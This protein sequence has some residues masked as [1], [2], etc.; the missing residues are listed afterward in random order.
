M[1]YC[2]DN[3]INQDEPATGDQASQ[4]SR[5]A[6]SSISERVWLAIGILLFLFFLTTTVAHLLT[7]QIDSE[8][9]Q[10][11][12]AFELVLEGKSESEPA[13]LA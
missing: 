1:K 4:R 13:K 5:K 2:V 10:I 12:R 9:T 7:R 6:D 8:V 11:V 3:R